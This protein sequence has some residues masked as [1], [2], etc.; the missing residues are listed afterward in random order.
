MEGGRCQGPFALRVQEHHQAITVPGV[1][2]SGVYSARLILCLVPQTC[3]KWLHQGGTHIQTLLSEVLGV[4]SEEGETACPAVSST[5]KGPRLGPGVK[6]NPVPLSRLGHIRLAR[7]SYL[8]QLLGSW[9]GAGIVQPGPLPWGWRP[10]HPFPSALPH[11]PLPHCKLWA[12]GGR[13]VRVW[14]PFIHL[15]ARTRDDSSPQ[16]RAPAPLC[17]LVTPPPGLGQHLLPR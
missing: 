3:F 14:G 2:R 5:L 7:S 16:G 10:S 4:F 11:C 12:Q 8:N 13:L 1:C 9:W 6:P 17:P 15:G